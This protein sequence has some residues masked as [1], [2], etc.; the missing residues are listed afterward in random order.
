MGKHDLSA[1]EMFWENVSRNA[2][3]ES[4]KKRENVTV[5]WELLIENTSDGANIS[6]IILRE[7]FT[8]SWIWRKEKNISRETPN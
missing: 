8:Q 7:G 1:D 5:S 6:T 2:N 3:G 4:S